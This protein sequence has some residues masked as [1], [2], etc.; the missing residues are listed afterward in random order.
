MGAGPL[1]SPRHTEPEAAQEALQHTIHQA[2][3]ELGQE[4]TRWKLRTLLATSDWLNLHT[5]P[6]MSQLL[7]RL[8][9]HWKRGRHHVHSPDSDYRAK[10]LTVRVHLLAPGIDWE[11]TVFVFEDEF[12]FYR[13]PSLSFAY[14]VAGKEQPLAELGW[15]RNYA[16]RIAATLNV[17]TGQVTYAQGQCFDIPHLVAFYQQ[18]SQTYS[19]AQIMMV[20]DNWPVHFHP[21]V[22]AALQP[23]EWRWNLHLPAHWPAQAGPGALHLH[24]P[25]QIL[26]LPTYASWTN[27]IEKLWRLLYQEVLHLHRFADDWLALKRAV[28]DFLD[29]FAAGSQE[30]LRYVGLS[31]PSKLYRSLFPEDAGLS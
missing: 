13:H 30:L 24:L 14:E 9:V 26:P 4:G 19:A 11:Q 7:H 1:F 2:P 12:T 27:P 28:T 25:I 15:K 21:D 5:L 3:Q 29:Q 20:Q 18:V 10:L 8:R 31:D 17:W 6:G 22:R 23:Q 16:W